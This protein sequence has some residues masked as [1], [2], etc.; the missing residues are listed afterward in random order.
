MTKAKQLIAECEVTSTTPLRLRTSDGDMTV[1]ITPVKNKFRTYS[2]KIEF[3]PVTV[4]S[5]KNLVNERMN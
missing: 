4:D 3:E 5:L 2:L 1:T